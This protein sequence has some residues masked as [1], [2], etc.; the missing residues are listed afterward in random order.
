MTIADILAGA[1]ARERRSERMEQR[2][3]PSVKQVIE[4][5]A[6][7]LG[8]DQSDFITTAAYER[9]LAVL[10][11]RLATRLPTE[12]FAAFA[13]ALDRPARPNPQLVELMAGYERGVDDPIR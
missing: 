10:E 11:D 3:R 13:A 9:A 6:T 5:A 7:T 1:V 12:R 4:A 8:Q 2:V